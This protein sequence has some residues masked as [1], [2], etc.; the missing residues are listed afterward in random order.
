MNFETDRIDDCVEFM[1]QLKIKQQRL[2]GSRPGELCVMATGGGAYKYYDK[3]H[4]A[5][6]VDVLREDEM[7]CLII[8]MSNS[9]ALPNKIINLRILQASIFSSL[10]SLEKSLHIVKQTRC[11]L[12][13]HAQIYTPTFLLTSGPACL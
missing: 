11:T 13:S 10:R 6:G 8:G 12:K 1:K 2:N 4:E 7:E 9:S 5:L 3:I